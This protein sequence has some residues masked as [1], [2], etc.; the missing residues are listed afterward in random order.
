MALDIAY[1]SLEER[2]LL[3]SLRMDIPSHEKEP[4]RSEAES[5]AMFEQ[6]FKTI[7]FDKDQARSDLGSPLHRG[8]HHAVETLLGSL[9]GYT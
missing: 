6:V 7:Y 4:T 5:L 1:D 2:I 8:L 9:P 3:R